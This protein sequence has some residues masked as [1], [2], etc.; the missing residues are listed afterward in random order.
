M[1]VQERNP[2]PILRSAY[3][4]ACE[5]KSIMAPKILSLY[6]Q[7]RQILYERR[8]EKIHYQ[9]LTLDGREGKLIFS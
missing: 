9:L 8:G 4:M 3:T 7:A 1:M 2:V 5:Q 6:L